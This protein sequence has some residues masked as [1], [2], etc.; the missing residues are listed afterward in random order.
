MKKIFIVTILILLTIN[1][2][3]VSGQ[4]TVKPTVTSSASPSAKIESDKKLIDQINNLKEKVASKVAE[5][6]LVEKQGIIGIVTEVTGNRILIDNINNS[7]R[8]IDV[9][10]LTKFSSPDNKNF[11]ISDIK[12]GT[13]LSVIGLFNKQS[14]HILARFVSVETIPVFITGTITDIDKV[15]YTISILTE[16]KTTTLIDIENVTK[17]S[18]YKSGEDTVVKLGFSKLIVGDRVFIAGYRNIKDKNRITAAR[19]ITFPGV[20]KNPKI[21]LPE[22]TSTEIPTKPASPSAK[23]KPTE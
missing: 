3:Q 10:E 2:K 21:N 4:T 12:K 6:Q 15:N 22:P 5:L 13:I 18:T 1:I 19:V 11:G 20:A 8:S 17:T 16:K 23:V 7:N 9:D 14:K